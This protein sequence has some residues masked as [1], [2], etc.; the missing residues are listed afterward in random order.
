[1]AK[2]KIVEESN[3]L[4]SVKNK[5][6]PRAKFKE[7]LPFRVR[8][9]NIKIEGY[10]PTNPGGIGVAVIGYNNYIL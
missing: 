3:K 2:A 9:I 10:S 7:T 5:E 8:F 6:F 4:R 1:M